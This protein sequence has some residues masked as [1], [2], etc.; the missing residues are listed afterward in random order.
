[1]LLEQ[2]HSRAYLEFLQPEAELAKGRSQHMGW[3]RELPRMRRRVE[4]ALQGPSLTL[5]LNC[6]EQVARCQKAS[7]ILVQLAVLEDN[8]QNLQKGD[9]R[10]YFHFTRVEGSGPDLAEGATII[11]QR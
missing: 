1:M 6:R 10:S 9:L 7:C 4:R 3:L 8:L 5:W 11:K 2:I